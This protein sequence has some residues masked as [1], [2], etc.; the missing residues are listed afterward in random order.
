[1][2]EEIV[3]KE[4]GRVRYTKMRIRSAY[5][6]LLKE[7]GPDRIT[8]TA[9]CSR[10]EI[11]RATFYKHY[12]DVED[13]VDKLQEEVFENLTRELNSTATKDNALGFIVNVLTYIKKSEKEAA[14]TGLFSMATSASFTTKIS[15][16]IYLKFSDVL[17]S[18]LPDSDSYNK[19]MV[20][21]YIAAGC[22]GVIDWWVKTGYSEPEEA[23]AKKLTHL[24][25]IT[26]SNI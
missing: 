10:A 17:K 25:S 11:N 15:R 26:I 22:A 2:S 1:M 18:R 24:A 14:T 8:V 21:A 23:I 20:F 5:Y 13:L 16:L 12:M 3:K 19:D 4:D 7:T 6:E 9:V